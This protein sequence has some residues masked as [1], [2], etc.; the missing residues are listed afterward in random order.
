MT[1]ASVSILYKIRHVKF[2]SLIR[3][4]WHREPMD[5]IGL[6]CGIDSISPSWSFRSKNPA[7]SLAAFENGG[8]LI[9]P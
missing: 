7:S 3:N 4:S 2:L 5:G 6:D 8:D 9:S 1:I